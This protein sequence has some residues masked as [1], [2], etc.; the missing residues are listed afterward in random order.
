MEKPLLMSSFSTTSIDVRFVR[1]S[2]SCS[3]R[4][5]AMI[6]WFS[7]VVTQKFGIYGKFSLVDKH[8]VNL[9]DSL[10][11]LLVHWRS[12]LVELDFN[13][14]DFFCSFVVHLIQLFLDVVDF[15]QQRK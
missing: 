3:A 5:S 4:L 14:H 9:G 8:V 2:V 15:F 11:S 12:Q 10:R 1:I 6:G 13:L 7:S